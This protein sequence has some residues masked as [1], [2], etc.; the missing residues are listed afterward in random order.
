MVTTASANTGNV[1]EFN[2]SPWNF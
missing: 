1:L 2:W